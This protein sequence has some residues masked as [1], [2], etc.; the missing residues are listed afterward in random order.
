MKLKHIILFGSMLVIGSLNAQNKKIAD[1]SADAWHIDAK[2][3]SLTE[4]K[5]KQALFLDQGKARLKNSSFKNGIIEYDI[6]FGQERNFAGVHF[7]IQDELNYEEYYLRP[8]QSGNPDA[9][10]YTPVVNGNAA[11]Q[12]YSGE[13]F[14]SSI[15]HRFGEW[16]HIKL[17][18]SRNKMD[19][20]IDDMEKPILHVSE[21]KLGSI[22]GGLGFGTFLGSAYYANLT[23]E[24][25]QEPKLV[26]KA[27]ETIQLALGTILDWKV[28]EA[29]PD[30]K[31]TGI[32]SLT[33][34]NIPIE[35][36]LKVD[37]SGILN[38]SHVSKVSDET[39]TILAKLEIDSAI[40]QL[41]KIDFGY[42][43][44]VT[45]FVNGKP[46]YHGDNSFRSRDYR[47]LGSIGYFDTVYLDLK[48]GKNEIVFAATEKMG[49][50]GVMARLPDVDELN[51]D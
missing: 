12:L 19:V 36:S 43:D 49:G 23:Y 24:E 18:V 26:T 39:N 45:L 3:H 28:S 25:I 16:M 15:A 20:F 22:S 41:K 40:D 11:W 21:L 10:Q 29:F 46:I 2:N 42:S 27:T 17:I 32:V 33:T 48:K 30:T 31:L 1:F 34:L 8:H 35:K 47:Y 37:A 14:W 6:N 4:Y 44:K 50:W 51:I 13:G 38:L 7:H 5:G 9:M